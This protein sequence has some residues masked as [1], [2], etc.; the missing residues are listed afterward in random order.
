MRYESIADIYSAN[1]RVRERFLNV[2]NSI[3]ANEAAT[4]AEGEKWPVGQIVE[5]V[6]IVDNS[7]LR[8]CTKLVNEAREAA[9]QSDGSFHLTDEFKGKFFGAADIKIE[10]PERVHPTGSISISDSLARLETTSAAID[11]L[12]SALELFDGTDHTFPHPH[13]GNLTAAEWLV[14]RGGHEN[15]HA[16]QI[17]RVLQK[18]RK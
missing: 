4:V 3:A 13:F 2:V 8:I 6:S 5:H 12:R 16:D 1:A 15:R 7:M 10:A 18:I 9:K 17:E 11:E 14:V